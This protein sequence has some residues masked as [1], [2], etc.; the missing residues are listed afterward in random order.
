[1]FYYLLN[2]MTKINQSLSFNNTGNAKPGF[3][4]MPVFRRPDAAYQ[5]YSG[6]VA[7]LPEK[8]AGLVVQLL[9]N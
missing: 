3:K 6:L 4:K 8:L 7:E 5:P 9:N 2:I 1:M